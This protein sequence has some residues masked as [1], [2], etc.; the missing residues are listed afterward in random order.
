MAFI[1]LAPSGYFL[2]YR[3]LQL[4]RKQD[5]S[6]LFDNLSSRLFRHAPRLFLTVLPVMLITTTFGVYYGCYSTGRPSDGT[7]S[8]T[9]PSLWLQLVGTMRIF[10]QML[11]PF[12][13]GE[14]HPPMVPQL[15]KLPMEFRG[16]MVLFMLVLA[17]G[18]A[19]PVVRMILLLSAASGYFHFIR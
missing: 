4:S 12:R 6:L 3:P 1:F 14:F 9:E 11:D 15:W 8:G 7:C 17:L 16:S 19:K 2:S 10:V 13:W 5:T 18:N